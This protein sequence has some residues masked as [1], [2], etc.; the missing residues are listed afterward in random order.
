MALNGVIDLRSDTVTHPTPAMREA[1]AA[2]EVGDDVFG[3]DPTVNRLQ[4]MAAARLGFEAALLVCSGTMGNL[5]ALLAHCGRGDEIIVG[6]QSHI[7]IY[8]GGGSAVIGG[9]HPRAI[10]NQPDGTL[11]LEDIEQA[12]RPKD[13]HHPETRLICLENTHNRMAGAALTPEYTQA[14]VALAQR[15]GLRVHIDGARIFNAAV[16]LGVDVRALTAGADSVMFCLSKGLG[17][18]VGSILCGSR[19]FIQLAH[20]RRKVLGGGMRQAGVIAAAG[21]VALEQMVDR[22]HEDHANARLLAEQLAHIPGLRVET[23]RVQ[24]NMVYFDLAPEVPIDAAELCRRTA[25]ERVRMLP[26]SSRRVRAVTHCWITRD[27]VLTSAQVIAH[28]L[29]S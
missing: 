2:A 9:I 15:H 7:Y 22:L 25:Q 18:P 20:R 13:A 19:A 28:V 10:P 5:T 21:I 26:I 12:I 27:D 1:M 4:E 24:T 3:E 14:V 29:Q 16:A 6:D 23:A 8:E 17:A 11:R